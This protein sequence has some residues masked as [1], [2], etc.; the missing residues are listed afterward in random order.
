MFICNINQLRIA[1][2]ALFVLWAAVLCGCSGS[3]QV[4]QGNAPDRS[5]AS[6]TDA[7]ASS[8]PAESAQDENA[9]GEGADSD[10]ESPDADEEGAV[11]TLNGDG[12]SPVGTLTEVVRVGQN[13]VR[14]TVNF[15]FEE[16][17]EGYSVC[18]ISSA[19]A[20]DAEGWCSVRRDVEI[21]QE[22]LLFSKEGA[23]VEVPFT[24][25]ASIGVGYTAYTDTV[26]IDLSEY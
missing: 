4:D 18:E 24:Y 14:I 26:V 3:P 6:Q 2:I 9:G 22:D 13:T 25:H 17:E 12:K 16:G 1:A 7:V 11:I 21:H 20:E 8:S 23:K 10:G 15:T 5:T 19:Y